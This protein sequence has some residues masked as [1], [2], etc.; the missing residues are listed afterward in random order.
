MA[1][2]QSP[3]AS[4]IFDL[5]GVIFDTD[6]RTI[7]NRA[8]KQFDGDISPQEVQNFFIERANTKPQITSRTIKPNEMPLAIA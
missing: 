5:G 2:L 3:K 8:C 7:V 6:T 4:I 1:G